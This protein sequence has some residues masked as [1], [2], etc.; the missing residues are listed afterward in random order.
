MKK[1]CSW[2]TASLEAQ[3][4]KSLLPHGGYSNSHLP[5]GTWR[6]FWQKSFTTGDNR[7]LAR[8]FLS[9]FT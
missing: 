9:L 3:V 6:S 5:P 1:P 8:W 2:V 4:G 7:N